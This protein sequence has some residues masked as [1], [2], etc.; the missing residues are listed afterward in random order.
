MESFLGRPTISYREPVQLG[1]TL[2]W[3]GMFGSQSYECRDTL[4]M[5]RFGPRVLL[6]L[7][8]YECICN[9]KVKAS[10]SGQSLPCWPVGIFLT[11]PSNFLLVKSWF[12]NFKALELFFVEPPCLFSNLLAILLLSENHIFPSHAQFHAS[13]TVCLDPS[14]NFVPPSYRWQFRGTW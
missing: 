11:V 8:S 1:D 14:Y 6:W 10:P 7:L 3:N 5:W 9:L 13:F 12:P 2:W 4:V